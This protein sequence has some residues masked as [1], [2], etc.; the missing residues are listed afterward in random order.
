M[1]TKQ[2][3]NREL[4]MKIVPFANKVSR[5]Y[6]NIMRFLDY[7]VQNIKVDTFSTGRRMTIE[8]KEPKF[9]KKYFLFAWEDDGVLETI[10]KSGLKV[11]DLLSIC[12]E[13]TTYPVD[14]KKVTDDKG[15]Q[16]ATA[17]RVVADNAF[18]Q[19]VPESDRFF[20]FMVIKRSFEKKP[21]VTAGCLSTEELIA[22]MVG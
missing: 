5:P 3:D 6:R 8:V 22:K 16:H 14:A 1:D 20:K 4:K 15:K 9:N 2:Q 10:E 12:V 13:M 21:A 11:G 17:W 7:P 19:G 18:P